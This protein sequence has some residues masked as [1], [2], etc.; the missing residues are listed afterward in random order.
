MAKS[1]KSWFAFFR[2]LIR[3]TQSESNENHD[4]SQHNIT[5]D[6]EQLLEARDMKVAEIMIP[7]A[8]LVA[9]SASSSVEEIRCKFIE[10]GFLRLTIYGKDLDDIVG[11][12]HLKDLFKSITQEGISLNNLI[13]KT[14]YAAK[15]TKCFSLFE[16]MKYEDVDIA[17]ILDEYGGIEGMISIERLMEEIMSTIQ[18][19]HNEEDKDGLSIQQINDNMYILDARTSIQKVEELF[20]DVEFLSEEEGEYETIGGFI[21]SYLDRVPSKGEKFNHVGGLEIEIIESTSRVIKK[22]KITRVNNSV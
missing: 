3:Q 20:N 15:S 16:K 9:M 10:T 7:R 4:T 22:I 2:K 12:I 18:N 17:V 21:L 13:R 8:D 19:S 5:E 1:K 11:F 6:L 14:I